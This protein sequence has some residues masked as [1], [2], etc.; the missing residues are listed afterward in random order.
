MNIYRTIDLCAGIGGIR[1]GFEL[2]GQTTNVLSAENDKYACM[3]YEHLYGENPMN[4]ITTDEFKDLVTR[5]S[6][7]ILLAGFPCQAFSAVGKRE[8]FRDA[9]R[10]TIFFHIAEILDATRPKAFL[11]E[12]VEGLIN[13]KKGSTFNTI[14][15]T[16]IN[17]LDYHVVGIQRDITGERFIFNRKD[18]LL[19][20]RNFGVPQNRPRVYIVGFDKKRYGSK[21][22]D[23]DFKVLPQ[24]R[25]SDPIYRDL[26]DVLEMKADPS[27]YLAQGYV[28][29]LKRHRASQ[30]AKGNGFGYMV[31]NEPNIQNPVSNAILATGGSGKE[32]NLVYDPQKEVI[33]LQVKGKQTPINDECIRLM[34]PCEW[35]KLQ[36]FVGYAFMENG[37]D[38]FSFPK[39]VSNTQQYKQFGNSVAIPVIEEI[40]K[41]VIKTL[42]ELE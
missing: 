22:E 42:D 29:T 2:T 20:A 1:R 28:D 6:Y 5:T 26:H 3:T 9:T 30:G 25:E 35:G 24:R 14:L 17:K 41:R 11:L 27:Y 8:G 21:L 40:A 10:G 33:G 37:E 34:K 38:K 7:D 19:N 31:V 23:I 18:I 39:G 36:G 12:N 32:R 15:D 16:L 4:D 13:H